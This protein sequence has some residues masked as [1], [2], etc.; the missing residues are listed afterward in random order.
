MSEQDR[1]GAVGEAVRGELVP[2][3]PLG[4]MREWAEE[5]VAQARADAMLR[6]YGIMYGMIKTTVYLPEDMKARIEQTATR[7][8]RSEADVIRQAIDRYTTPRERPRARLPLFETLRDPLFAER[9][10]E[11]LAGFGR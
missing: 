4:A 8:G 7:E 3:R 2:A 11:E 6:T 5:L 9:V 10:D 1:G